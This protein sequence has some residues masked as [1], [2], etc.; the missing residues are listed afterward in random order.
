MKIKTFHREPEL[1]YN[2]YGAANIA[3]YGMTHLINLMGANITYVETGVAGGSSLSYI[4][5]RCE[6]IKS[7]YG[8]D[9]FKAF[10]D[11]FNTPKLNFSD[12]QGKGLYASAKKRILS[13]GEKDKV[14]LILEHTD[15]ALNYFDDNSID[16]LFLDHYLNEKDVA[17]SCDNWYN[18]VRVGGYFAGHDWPYKGVY[19]EVFK[20]RKRNNIT[21]PLSIFGAEWVWK[22]EGNI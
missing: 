19:Q 18:K 16:F 9:H 7:A 2:Y 13:S 22:K 17:E 3:N 12:N 8:I 4:V 14:T 20:F 10:K 11:E 6:N 1:Q 21:S 5:Q 15:V